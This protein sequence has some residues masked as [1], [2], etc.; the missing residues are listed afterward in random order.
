MDAPLIEI[1]ST[2]IR[3]AIK[4]NKDIRF[5]VPDKVWEEINVSGFYK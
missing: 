1:S 2:F 4:T 3:N 5:F